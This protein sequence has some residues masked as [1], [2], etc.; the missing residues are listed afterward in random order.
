MEGSK[1]RI[2]RLIGTAVP[3]ALLV[4]GCGGGGGD[5]AKAP[6]TQKSSGSG[7]VVAAESTL[8][9]VGPT[10]RA[11]S[12]SKQFADKSSRMS[13]KANHTTKAQQHH[14][15]SDPA[16]DAGGTM[17]DDSNLAQLNATIRCLVNAERTNNGN[18]PNLTESD[19]LDQAAAGMCQRMVTEQFFSHVTPDGKDVVDRIEPT[20]YIPKSG[21]W[22]VG[23]NL[24]WGSGGLSTP[25][26]IVNGWMASAGHRA[27]ILAP[28]YKDIGLA[29]CMGAPSPDLSGGTVYVN[30]FGAKSGADVNLTLPSEGGNSNSSGSGQADLASVA[31][32]K[33]TASKR[34]KA[35]A[36]AKRRRRR[37]CV[38]KASKIHNKKRRHAAV[39]RCRRR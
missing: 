9:L 29:A 23:E 12:K 36:A 1:H 13:P 3:V 19:Q 26:A 32:A 33:A 6:V 14:V 2:R 30:N 16:C 11:T 15:S 8:G 27:N 5:T 10:D 37:A 7:A 39:S 31:G 20:G 24:A 17:P 38:H 35:R 22:V 4:A 34:K 21:D 18:L 25:Q 28:D